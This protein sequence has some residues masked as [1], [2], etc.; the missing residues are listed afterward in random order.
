M[1]SFKFRLQS[2]LNLKEQIEKSVKNELGVA[3]QEYQRQLSILSDIRYEIESQRE[4]YRDE[5]MSRTTPTKLK[6]RINYIKSM[7]TKEKEQQA[8]V[9]EHKRNV[10]KIRERLVEIMKEKKILEKL[11]EKQS[12]AFRIEQ[13][14]KQQL[15]ID[16]IISF[17]GTTEQ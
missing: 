12:Q 6:Q 4:K 14:K 5:A 3:L 1:A 7:Q 8:T 17:K 11:K 13:E 16:E 15:L 10:D 9:N 2:F